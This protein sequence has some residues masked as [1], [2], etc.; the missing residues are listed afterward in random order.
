MPLASRVVLLLSIAIALLPRTVHAQTLPA[1]F[2]QTAVFTGLTQPT[3]VKFARDGRV[4]V[5]EKSGLI[6]VFANLGDTTPTVFADLRT[7]VHNFWDR[8]L[9]GLELH[10]DFPTTP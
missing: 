8:G 6:K 4:F 5:A 7:N 1:G 9:L 10:P 3:A 2:Q